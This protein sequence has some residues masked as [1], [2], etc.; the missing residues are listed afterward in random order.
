MKY[1]SIRTL[2][3]IVNQLDLELHQVDVSTVFLNGD[4]QE[5]IYMKQP[6]G[7]VKQGN[8]TS[9]ASLKKVSTV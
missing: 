7:Y 6:K 2:C 4:L 5:E 1:T 3:A 8:R 9:F